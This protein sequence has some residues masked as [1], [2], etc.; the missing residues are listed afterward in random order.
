VLLDSGIGFAVGYGTQD[1]TRAGRSDPSWHYAQVTY[2]AD[3]WSGG[4][5]AFGLDYYS[6][7]DFVTDGSDSGAWGIGVIQKIAARDIELYA[8]HRVHSFDQPGTAYQDLASYL[9]GVRWKF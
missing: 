1:D 3:L 9:V 8:S 7:S 5:T 2:E 6:G 4:Q